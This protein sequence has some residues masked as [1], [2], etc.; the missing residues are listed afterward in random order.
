LVHK[1]A[2]DLLVDVEHAPTRTGGHHPNLVAQNSPGSV[3]PGEATPFVKP[4]LQRR[5]TRREGFAAVSGKSMRYRMSGCAVEVDVPI[6]YPTYPFSVGNK[7]SLVTRSPTP[8]LRI[9]R[10]VAFQAGQVGSPAGDR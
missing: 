4:F 5:D 7:P 9:I 6:L 2:D 1:F 3:H 8:P 10:L